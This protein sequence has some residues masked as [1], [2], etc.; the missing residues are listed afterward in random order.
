MARTK[1]SATT[2]SATK[3]LKKMNKLKGKNQTIDKTPEA[4]EPE[5]FEND[6]NELLNEIEEERAESNRP[7]ATL[8]V[9]MEAEEEV[10]KLCE[11]DVIHEVSY[12]S[13]AVIVYV[14]GANPPN[15]VLIGFLKRV[16]VANGIDSIAVRNRGPCIV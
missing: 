3:V 10:T 14:L 6:L 8:P 5:Q 16:W 4:T 9:Q 11:A 15:T 1:R 12:W 2:A 7:T 13:S